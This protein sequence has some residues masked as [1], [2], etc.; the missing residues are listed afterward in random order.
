MSVFLAWLTICCLF[1]LYRAVLVASVGVQEQK[2]VWNRRVTKIR[3]DS[4]FSPIEVAAISKGLAKWSV[5][6]GGEIVFEMEVARIH[7]GELFSWAEDEAPTIYNAT[8]F[9]GWPYHVAQASGIYSSSLGFTIVETA[10][11]FIL[12][13]GRLLESVI[14][15]E[16]GHVIIGSYHSKNENDL[17]YST[18]ADPKRISPKDAAMAILSVGKWDRKQ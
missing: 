14:T 10:D 3:V 13:T 1:S 5:A 12:H 8:S 16:A 4:S 15:H 7:S 11:V 17:M 18:I 9:L 2:T 6:T